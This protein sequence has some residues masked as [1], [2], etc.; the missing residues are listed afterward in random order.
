MH[1]PGSYFKSWVTV[2]SQL[3]K[4][5]S[6][7]TMR[8]PSVLYLLPSIVLQ[9]RSSPA[10]AGND[11]SFPG[12]LP[13]PP[14]VLGRPQL[15]SD[16]VLTGFPARSVSSASP[17]DA[18]AFPELTVSGALDSPNSVTPGTFPLTEATPNP[19][20]CQGLIEDLDITGLGERQQPSRYTNFVSQGIYRC[21]NNVLHDEHPHRSPPHIFSESLDW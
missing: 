7:T 16:P 8:F 17:F 18:S 21:S 1:W 6:P 12:S 11:K 20:V 10:A 4:D 9:T 19:G 14:V 15:I 3:L 5:S 13:S 2:Q